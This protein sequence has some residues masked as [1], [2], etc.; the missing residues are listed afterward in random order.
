MTFVLRSTAKTIVRCCRAVAAAGHHRQDV[1]PIGQIET[2]GERA[3]AADLH[4]L[5]AQGSRGRR[6][7][8]RRERSI[9]YR[10]E[11]RTRRVRRHRRSGAKLQVGRIAD[12][13]L[14]PLLEHLLQSPLA[15][16][17]L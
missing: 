1:P 17:S 12:G 3:V 4:R 16:G 8:S 13:P 6:A 10:P 2:D 15:S 7:G 11:N 14:Q 9:R 5:A